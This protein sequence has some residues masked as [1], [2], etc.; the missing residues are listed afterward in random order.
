VIGHA[1]LG[2]RCV[3][4]PAIVGARPADR[5]EPRVAAH[6]HD[7]ADGDRKGPVD[8]LGLRDV[9]HPPCL[10][11]GRVAQDLDPPGPG[12]QEAGHELEQRALAG[13]V[14][15]DD[16]GDLA[17]RY[18]EVE[19]VQRQAPAARVMKADPFELD[20]PC[21]QRRDRSG[22]VHHL[23]VERQ[24]G[25]QVPKEEDV[26]KRLAQAVDELRQL[27]RRNLRDFV[28]LLADLEHNIVEA[29]LAIQ[30]LLDCNSHRFDSHCRRRVG[31]EEHH[32]IIEFFSEDDDGI[33]D[34]RAG[35]WHVLAPCRLQ[36][37]NSKLGAEGG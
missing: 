15:P 1:D 31:V 36:G 4:V 17:G 24:E 26:D 8:E 6:H 9:R 32:P 3:D 22:R 29:A 18:G 25:E 14:R 27:F 2:E 30:Q 37:S 20:C 11:A 10:L 35:G 12:S 23:W 5:S 33:G 21:R 13:P 34:R 28:I 19:M 7:I 16:G